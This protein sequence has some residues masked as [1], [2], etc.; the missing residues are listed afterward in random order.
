LDQLSVHVFHIDKQSHVT[1]RLLPF[2]TAALLEEAAPA[3]TLYWISRHRDIDDAITF[4]VGFAG[5][6]SIKKALF[7][8]PLSMSWTFAGWSTVLCVEIF[9][10]HIALTVLLYRVWRDDHSP[11]FKAG[12][13]SAA[14]LYHVLIDICAANAIALFGTTAYAVLIWSVMTPIHIAVIWGGTRA[15][16]MDAAAPPAAE[17]P[18]TP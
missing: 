8:L 3:A 14:I 17:E 4:G 6:E 15:F 16:R 7:D 9:I 18:V 2:Y 1:L 10:F 11:S 13:I 12:V 5:F